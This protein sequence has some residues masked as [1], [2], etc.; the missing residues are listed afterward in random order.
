ME[1]PTRDVKVTKDWKG[2]DGN[3]LEAPIGNIEVELYKD[4]NPTGIKKELTK[5]NNWTATFEKLAVYESI[6]NQAIHKY[7]VKEVE[8]NNNSIKIEDSWY[9]VSITG[10][11][12]DGFTI[13]NMKQPPLT[14][15]EPPTRDV[16]VIKDWKGIKPPVDKIEVELYKDGVA[17]GIKKELTKAN[18]W[19]TTF[20]KLKLS[21]TLEGKAYEYTVKEVGENNGS[22]TFDDKTFKVSYEGNMKDGFK[23]IN[24]YEKP[25]KPEPKEPE[26]PK[27]PNTESKKSV[28][29]PK[30]G[31]SSN[32]FL[33]SLAL[34]LSSLGLLSLGFFRRKRTKEN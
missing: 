11:M 31:D 30:T 12:K 24:K 25:K 1:P 33:Y 9:K 6:T 8:E 3:I 26:K 21:A 23:V 16:K 32:V 7:T 14:P 27:V 34:G 28:T 18:N 22:V 20:E 4:G 10:D 5:D 13:T 15:M 19:T 2:A 29:L 17:T